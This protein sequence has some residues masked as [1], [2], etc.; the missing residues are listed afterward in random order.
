MAAF[1]I[2][3]AL[4]IRQCPRNVFLD[5]KPFGPYKNR[6][7]EESIAS[8]I[9]VKRI[10]DLGIML[11]ITS[12]ATSV[13]TTATLPDIPEDGILHS[14]CR[15]NLSSYIR[16]CSFAGGYQLSIRSY[17]SLAIGFILDT[18]CQGRVLKP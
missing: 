8:I 2:A 16:Q 13:L 15:E 6:R 4:I 9:R 14:H 3:T 10:R 17:D 11:A 12:Q 7:Y 1:L 18:L 5:V